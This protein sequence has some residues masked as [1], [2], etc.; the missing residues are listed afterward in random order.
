MEDGVTGGNAEVGW[1]YYAARPYAAGVFYWTGF[2]YRGEPTPFGYPAV[3][4]QFGILDTCGFPKDSYYYLKSW[5]G[6]ETVLHIFP[7]W[8]W[9]GLEGQ[10]IAVRVHSNCEEVELLL[11]GASLGRKKMELNGHLEWSVKYTPGT[12]L[13]RG[14]RGGRRIITRRVDATG[15]AASLSLEPDRTDL[16]AESRDVAVVTVEVRDGSARIVPTAGRRVVFSVRG[17]GQIIGVGNGDPSSHEPDRFVESVRSTPIG[18]WRAPDPAVTAGSIAFEAKFD[19]PDTSSDET[20]VLLLN[21]LGQRQSAF[22]NGEPLYRDED[23]A[24][25]RTEIRLDLQKLRPVGNVLPIEASRFENWS[26]REGLRQIHPASILITVAPKP[27]ARSTF[28]GL[29]QVIVQSTGEPGTII[30]EATSEGL[31]PKALTLVSR[32]VTQRR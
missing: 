16:R 13:A 5:W 2:D 31:A 30:L 23:P 8:N 27:W 26:R 4:S 20:A 6:D 12:L 1:R 21:A 9:P 29:A 28:N 18:E 7:H 11:N 17:P 10:A 22:L 24:K 14:Y 19:R 3:G 25:A 15:P 32:P